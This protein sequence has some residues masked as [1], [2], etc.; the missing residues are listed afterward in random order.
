MH[1]RQSIAL[2][3]FDGSAVLAKLLPLVDERRVQL[4]ER[5]EVELTPGENARRDQ[6]P[7]SWC[8]HCSCI[9]ATA[10]KLR[11]APHMEE[12]TEKVG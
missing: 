4:S 6:P 2:E 10:P 11:P 1:D 7:Q 9:G 8:R 12:A 3:L 5:F